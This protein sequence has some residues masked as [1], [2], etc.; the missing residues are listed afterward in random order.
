MT[1]NQTPNIKTKKKSNKFI[2][3]IKLEKRNSNPINDV[4]D[5]INEL[6]PF[7]VLKKE[8]IT[9]KN[10]SPE[11]NSSFFLEEEDKKK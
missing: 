1:Y 11:S 3:D 2:T 4:N 7:F 8:N 6:K 9:N 5:D 10:N